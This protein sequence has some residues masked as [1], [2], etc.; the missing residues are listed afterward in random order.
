MSLLTLDFFARLQVDLDDVDETEEGVEVYKEE[1]NVRIPSSSNHLKG[2][3]SRCRRLIPKIRSVFYLGEGL[4]PAGI[5]LF[6]GT[7]N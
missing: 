1:D 2:N 4:G 5:R 3:C 7:W 6:S